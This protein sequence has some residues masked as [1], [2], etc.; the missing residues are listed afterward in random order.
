MIGRGPNSMFAW[1]RDRT[2]LLPLR[3]KLSTLHFHLCR[4]L[5]LNVFDCTSYRAK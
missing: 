4:L 5:K 1:S 3:K 2:T